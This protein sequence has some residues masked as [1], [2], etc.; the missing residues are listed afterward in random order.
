MYLEFQGFDP[1]IALF[2]KIGTKLAAQLRSPITKYIGLFSM[3]ELSVC[4]KEGD[5]A[6]IGGIRW[7]GFLKDGF[8]L[9]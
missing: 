9:E 6:S 4:S 8:G 7:C 2:Q 1:N 5:D 3:K